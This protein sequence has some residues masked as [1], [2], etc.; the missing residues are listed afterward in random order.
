MYNFGK[1]NNCEIQFEDGVNIVYG[2]NESGKTTL[3]EFIKAMFYGITRQRGRASRNDLYTRYEPWDNSSYFAGDLRFESGT[4]DFKITRNFY[5]N[6]IKEELI[7]ETDGERLSIEHGDMDVLLGDISEAVFDNTLSVG[8]M[9]SRT[10]ESLYQELRNYMTNYEGSGDWELD[11]RQALNS[12]K[13]QK[14][15]VDS[16]QRIENAQQEARKKELQTQILY[17]QNELD[18]YQEKMK[19][20]DKEL[21]Q[22]RI[23]ND[24]RDSAVKEE[25]EQELQKERPKKGWLKTEDGKTDWIKVTLTALILITMFLPIFL[26]GLKI[27][28]STRVIEGIIVPFLIILLLVRSMF[29]RNCKQSKR[30][31]EEQMQVEVR[32]KQYDQE[33]K[34]QEVDEEIKHL[35]WK[36]EQLAEMQE[37]KKIQL[38]NC[39]MDYWEYS[40]NTGGKGGAESEAEAVQLAM[41][42]ISEVSAGGTKR[43]ERDFHQRISEILKEITGGRYDKVTLDDKHEIELYGAGKISPLWMLSKGTI[44]QVY[45]ALR[46]AAAELFCSE[47]MPVLLDDVFVMYD[48]D[49]LLAALSWLAKNK[50]QVIMFTCNTREAKLAKKLNL[51][52]NE[53]NL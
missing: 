31:Q 44:E 40:A 32:N 10:D 18:T 39:Q 6:D 53:I 20:I 13:Q 33:V 2:L 11:V 4:K 42:S 28:V 43:M 24:E 34:H 7:C 51:R 26:S 50:K 12:L 38:E 46:M 9:R 45:F 35:N 25:L 17:F 52:A 36:R 14:K 1:L 48:E 41:D 19:D 8:Q 49:R 22:K 47:D 15:E 23:I 5:K 3:H 29:M 21:E 16:Q 37:E 30:M 27:K